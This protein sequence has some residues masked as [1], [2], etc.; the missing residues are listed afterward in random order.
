MCDVCQTAVFKDWW[1]KLSE[2]GQDHV[3][4]IVELLQEMGPQ[5]PSPTPRAWRAPGTAICVS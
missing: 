1:G 5:L 3:T 2:Q 4:A